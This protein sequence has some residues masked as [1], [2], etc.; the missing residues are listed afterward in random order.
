MPVYLYWGDDEF[1]LAKAVDALRESILDPSWST[2][3]FDKI[4]PDS[5]NAVI[6]GLNQAMTPP[7][8]LGSRLVWL[9]NT[10]ITQ[11]CSE[12]ILKELQRTL[13]VIPQTTT[14]LLT[15]PNKP[16]GRL[17]STKLLQQQATVQEFSRIPPW[18]T[19]QLEQRVKQVAA[20]LGV[21]L[22]SPGVELLAE[23]VGND[24]Q[25]LYN[26]LEKLKLYAGNDSKALKIEAIASLVQSNTQN[27]LKLAN[28]IKA[29][30]THQALELIAALIDHNEPGLRIV[31][32]L[33]GQ[34]RTWLWVKLMIDRQVKDEREIAKA[35][36]ISNPKR[37]YFLRQEVQSLSVNQLQQ[38]LPLL[39]ELETQLK[40]GSDEIST[41]QTHVIALCNLFQSQSRR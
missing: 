34:F 27:S 33:V 7:F 11:H 40:R 32:T 41:L 1:S 3:N 24:T 39:L 8:G 37:I 16:D 28:A 22:T 30:N 14:L 12:D 2:F 35:A 29:G 6:S 18:K 19:D 13:E 17:K 26:E 5:P 20:Q 21:K 25:Q 10:P 23:A 15:T 38:S 4:L 36:E 9:V 31:A